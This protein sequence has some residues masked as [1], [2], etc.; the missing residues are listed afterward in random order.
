M[1]TFKV[2]NYKGNIIESLSKFQKSHKGM[3]IVEACEDGKALKIK[4]EES[5]DDQEYTQAD[6]DFDMLSTIEQIIGILDNSGAYYQL[7]KNDNPS[8]DERNKFYQTCYDFF[9]NLASNKEFL[10]K[11]LDSDEMQK[12][13]RNIQ[14]LK[15]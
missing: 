3:K 14:D 15:A 8:L 6:K 12:L 11:Y 9:S 2:K 5:I 1:K 7:S 10:A 4:A 13:E